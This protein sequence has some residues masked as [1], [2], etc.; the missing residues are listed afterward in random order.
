MNNYYI[1]SLQ[2]VEA[3]GDRY[4][5]FKGGDIIIIPCQEEATAFGLALRYL[6]T[7]GQTGSYPVLAKGF[8][9]LEEAVATL[10]G[11]PWELCEV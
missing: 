9:T 11:E 7:T 4:F 1:V 8:E 2:Y 5:K 3:Y 10:N 6:R